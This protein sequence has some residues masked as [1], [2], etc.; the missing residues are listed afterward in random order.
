MKPE[1][2][3]LGLWNGYVMQGSDK[4]DRQA[5]LAE[6]PAHLQ[7]D[8]RRHVTTVFELRRLARLRPKGNAGI[9]GKIKKE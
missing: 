9:L 7:D 6:C 3:S 8:V 4:A 5:R 1:T 2:P